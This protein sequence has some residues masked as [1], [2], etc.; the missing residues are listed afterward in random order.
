M[1]R[2]H[3]DEPR[4]KHGD[5]VRLGNGL[6]G[7]IYAP[8]KRGWRSKWTVITESGQRVEAEDEFVEPLNGLEKLMNA[9]IEDDRPSGD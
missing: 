9:L 5:V 8:L 3:D 2:R 7:K 4:F 1:A 6:V